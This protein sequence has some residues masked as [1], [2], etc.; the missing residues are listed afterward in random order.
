MVTSNLTDKHYLLGVLRI[1]Q[2][3]EGTISFAIYYGLFLIFDLIQ[4]STGTDTTAYQR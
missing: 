4:T 2:K 1:L 3:M